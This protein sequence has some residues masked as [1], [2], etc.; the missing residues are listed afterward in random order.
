MC[1]CM[2]LPSTQ[3][4]DEQISSHQKGG[5]VSRWGEWVRKVTWTAYKCGTCVCMPACMC[6]CACRRVSV[7]VYIDSE[8]CL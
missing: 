2:Q 5:G 6:V 3:G 1:A 8:D 7:C 4:F